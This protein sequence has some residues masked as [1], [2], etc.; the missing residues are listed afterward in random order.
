MIELYE[1]GLGDTGG[2]KAGHEPEFVLTAQ[3]NH[4]QDCISRNC[5]C[6]TRDMIQPFYTAMEAPLGVSHPALESSAQGKYD[7]KQKYFTR[8]ALKH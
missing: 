8:G 5:G 6:M 4:I 1:E 2:R 3:E 7:I